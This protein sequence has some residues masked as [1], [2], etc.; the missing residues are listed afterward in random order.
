MMSTRLIGRSI[1]AGEV[2]RASKELTEAVDTWREEDLSRESFT[3]IFVDGVMFPMRV[4][5]SIEYCQG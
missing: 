4:D 5:G 1:S 2:S 3:S